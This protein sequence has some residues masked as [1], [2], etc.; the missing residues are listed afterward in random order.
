M[1]FSAITQFPAIAGRENCLP[2]RP[3]DCQP[4]VIVFRGFAPQEIPACSKRIAARPKARPQLPDLPKPETSMATRVLL[5]RST[6]HDH[7]L[8]GYDAE[9]FLK[10]PA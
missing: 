9:C 3:L 1:P 5:E 4:L 2:R 6:P 8:H 10:I 7:A